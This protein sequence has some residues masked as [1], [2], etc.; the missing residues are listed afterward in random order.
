MGVK[1]RKKKKLINF[2]LYCMLLAAMI[3]SAPGIAVSA[4][5]GL[6]LTWDGSG[7]YTW[8]SNAASPFTALGHWVKVVD[9][10][11]IADNGS[12][13][14]VT[15]DYPNSGPTHTLWFVSKIDDYSAMYEFWDD[16]L[17]QP[18]NALQYSGPYIYRVEDSTGAWSQAEDDLQVST[19]NPPD[20]TT[21]SPGFNTPQSMIAYFDNVFTNNVLYDDFGL[22]F[23]DTKWESQP[24]E[25]TY[26]GGEAR[27]ERTW[28]PESQSVWMRMTDP[29]TVD[30]LRATVRVD[31]ISTNDGFIWARIGGGY[32]RDN[33]GEVHAR[34]G[35][36]GDDTY[37]S[38]YSEY[39]DGDH[40]VDKPLLPSTS[41]G[42]VTQ[43]RNYEL[44]L[45]WD[46]ASATF[47][48]RVLG[49]DDSVDYTA[50]YTVP[51]TISP[52]AEPS[53]SIGISRWV[54][55]NTTTPTFNWPADPD[56]N[57]YRVR[58][59]GLNDERIF[60][61][62]V[63]SPPYTIPPGVLKPNAGYKLRIYA[64]RDHLWF[65]WDNTAVSNQDKILFF[66][67]PDETEDPYIDL[68][69]IG[70]ETWK[71]P[72]PYDANTWFYVKIHDAQGVPD[73]IES[74]KVRFPD[75]VTELTLYYDE[76]LSARPWHDSATAAV[77]R[78]GYFGAIQ[79]G[80]YTFT[81]TDRD[82]NTAT[83]SEVL[84]ADP[85]DYPPISTLVPANN[86][87]NGG[88]GVSF[89][90]GDVTGAAFYELTLYDKDMNYLFNVK[91]T[92]SEYA[93]PPGILEENS[94]YRYRIYTRREFP[95][96]NMD[97][98]STIPTSGE[99][100]SNTFFTTAVSGAVAPSLNLDSFGVAVWQ[101]PHPET[102]APAY[103]LE[104]MALVAD[105]DGVPENI[106]RVEVTYPDGTTKRILKY[107]DWPIWGS[108]YFDFETYSDLSLIQDTTNSSGIYTFRVVDF[109]GNEVTLT[110]TLPDV[111]S[112]VLPWPTGVFPSEGYIV[113]HTTPFITWDKALGAKYYKVRIMSDWTSPTVHWSADLTGT[114]YT[115]PGG[116]ISEGDTYSLRVY[117]FREDIGNEVDFY[118]SSRSSHATN[119][120]FT[121]Q[122][123]DSDEDGI[124]DAWEELY[125]LNPAV[126]DADGDLD[127]DGLS[128][129]LEYQRGLNPDNQDTDGDTYSDA[130]DAFPL[131]SNEWA[132]S[133][134][135]GFGD[136]SD[137]DKDNDGIADVNDNCPLTLN[138]EQEDF[139]EDTV[140]DA[141][142]NCPKV[143]NTSQADGDGDGMG[144]ACEPG[145]G[146]KEELT[147]VDTDPQQPGEPLPKQP[148]EPLWVTATFENN[149]PESIETIKPDCFNTSFQV[150]DVYGNTLPPRYRIRAAYGIPKD[151]VTLPPGPFSVTCDLAD[152]FPPEILKDPVP[153]DGEPEPYTV[154]ATYSNDIQDPD[155][156]PD[157]GDCLDPP[158]SDLFVG[159][160]TSPPAE[161]KIEGSSVETMTANCIMDPAEW[162]PQW[163]VVGGPIISVFL[164]IADSDGNSIVDDVEPST[165]LLNGTLE[166]IDGSDI[167]DNG[168]LRVQFDGSA[169]I[170]S[171]GTAVPGQAITTI[172]GSFK[173]GENVFSG[174]GP[175]YL[176]Y[177]IDIKPGGYPN[178]INRRQKGNVSVAILSTP[179]F[180]AATVNPETVTLEGTPVKRKKK[181][182]PM[183]S[184]ED[185][186]DDGYVD[187]IVHFDQR[188]LSLS[189][190]DT[191]AYLEGMTYGET[192]A[193]SNYIKGVDTIKIVK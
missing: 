4:Q 159:A 134:Q 26:A 69:H 67:G 123:E 66:T 116:I 68:W 7:V 187:L 91:T 142:D 135:D 104:F 60:Q 93:L 107:N 186:N 164:T 44:T 15:V 40:V 20:E 31:S 117:A 148:G 106:E 5:P 156:D 22:G 29:E 51:G 64:R 173:S 17:P 76:R 11:G 168:V 185:V 191:I 63:T 141:C 59:Y 152:M 30:E 129:I 55:F 175:V 113:N 52:I 50:S 89:D 145:D 157:T 162:N 174:Q 79:P 109:D 39:W 184:L 155:I 77:Y 124:P 74:V 131:N 61:E 33:D 127:E 120:R 146:F 182:K 35:I 34:V 82:N 132:D 46:Y 53:R 147:V 88:T 158:C 172:Q 9:Y 136:N 122:T 38:V 95:E 72:P 190:G 96:E 21:F 105:P 183:V 86:E 92:D 27:F 165:I 126:D 83:N 70:V 133:D 12:S 189:K 143:A 130:Q 180:D 1:M 3:F 181:N 188:Q 23:V 103:E 99:F 25:V 111:A 166:I 112:N 94:L 41:L 108:N 101:A 161:V 102:G 193:D 32:C 139:D 170:N 10:D 54:D 65:D 150:K 90:W 8:T 151:V 177:P 98:G 80:L 42:P 97:N 192:P 37:I 144:N 178:S 36:Q 71:D 160:V 81:V 114:Q 154:V 115:I 62:Y 85:I 2:F 84:T 6:D 138:P 75:N 110:D 56:A 47:E 19:I 43:G 18:I 149:S 49:L 24:A 119:Y 100:N 176:L 140:G 125:G 163:A 169:A 48:F 171:M 167:V 128:N 58:I 121:I 87:L 179:D 73:N 118:S 13:H 16:T 153:A 45:D 78:A 57:N 14:T 28:F 137:S